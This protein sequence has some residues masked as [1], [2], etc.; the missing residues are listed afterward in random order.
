[1]GAVQ[2]C[3][4]IAFPFDLQRCA[5]PTLHAN[6]SINSTMLPHLFKSTIRAATQL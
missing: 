2:L 1:M 5:V 4:E 6:S 3:V